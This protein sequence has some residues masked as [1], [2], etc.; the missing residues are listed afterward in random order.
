ML[1]YPKGANTVPSETI[2][3]DMKNKTYGIY[4][5]A[6]S[7]FSKWDRGTDGLRLFGG[8]NTIGRVYEIGKSTILTDYNETTE[9]GEAITA[10][11]DYPL[12]MG[13][14]EVYK[15]WYSIF[16]KIMTTGGTALAMFY[17]LDD[18]DETSS[19]I[20]SRDDIAFVDGGAGVEDT[21]TTTAGDFVAAGF[22]AGDVIVVTGDSENNGNYTIVSVVAKTINVATASLTGEIKGDDVVITKAKVLTANTTKWYRIG[23]GSGGKRARTLTPRPYMSDKYYFEIQGYMV[24]YEAEPFAEEKE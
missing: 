2:W 6:F 15:Q 10:Y 20:I 1:C 23:L 8:S 4:D 7:C 12:D 13:I 14:P 22:V 11:D 5:F 18:N 19:N 21:I 16:I 24:C 9:A 3:I 17:T